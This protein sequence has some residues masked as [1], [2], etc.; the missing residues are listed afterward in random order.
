MRWRTEWARKWF[1]KN[2]FSPLFPYDYFDMTRK[3][4]KEVGFEYT[5][6]KWNE[7]LLSIAKYDLLK[8]KQEGNAIRRKETINHAQKC[9]TVLNRFFKDK[10]T[11]TQLYD[12]VKANL[13]QEYIEKLPDLILKKS[14]KDNKKTIAMPLQ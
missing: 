6:A 10:I 7:H 1:T 11:Y 2:Q 4:S 12:Y 3:T 8:K 14:L 5:K 13:P 9:E